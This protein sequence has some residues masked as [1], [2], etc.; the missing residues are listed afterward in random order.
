MGYFVELPPG[1]SG[2]LES[3]GSKA[4]KAFVE[5]GGTLVALSAATDYAIEQ[6]NIPVVNTLSRVR[7]EEFGCP[8]SLL[9]ARVATGH[10]VTWGLPQETALF[11]DKPIAFQTTPPGAE[12][13]RWVLASYPEDPHDVLLSGWLTGEEKLTRRAAAVALT[14]GQGQLVLLGF[15]PQHRDQ[16]NGTFP[17]LFNALHWSA[18]A[19]SQP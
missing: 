7:P 16:T 11:V 1:Y 8:G 10:P 6:F 12:L 2:G 13:D 15:R 3:E 14:F 18:M 17:F 9:R 4:L 19:K 5:E